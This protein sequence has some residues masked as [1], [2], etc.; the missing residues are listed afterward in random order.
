M[1]SRV[2]AVLQFANSVCH[3]SRWAGRADSREHAERRTLERALGMVPSAA[4]ERS[5]GKRRVSTPFFFRIYHRGV[6]VGEAL[7]IC[8]ST[9]RGAKKCKT[10]G[11][12]PFS[13]L[14]HDDIF[15]RLPER[16][17]SCERVCRG[18]RVV[19]IVNDLTV[20]IDRDVVLDSIRGKSWS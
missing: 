12:P 1:S 13:F 14:F 9:A 7:R 20:C 17:W 11:L 18:R 3:I 5:L 16:L 15:S 4:G 8:M 10:T 6:A 19:K 2:L